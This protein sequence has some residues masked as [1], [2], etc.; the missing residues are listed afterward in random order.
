M[1]RFWTSVTGF[2]ICRQNAGGWDTEPGDLLTCGGILPFNAIL[3]VLRMMV[4]PEWTILFP[5]EQP[6][7]SSS[8]RPLPL[9][10]H[11]TDTVDGGLTFS[12]APFLLA[13]IFPL[14]TSQAK[15]RREYLSSF[16][17]SDVSAESGG[18][19]LGLFIM[20]N[21]VFAWKYQLG[22]SS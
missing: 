2:N 7:G 14:L 13:F 12:L 4:D 21:K 5:K 19:S 9:L 11:A 6:L 8:R 3:Y 15:R 20:R 16:S 1:F 10:V 22:F 17:V 18:R